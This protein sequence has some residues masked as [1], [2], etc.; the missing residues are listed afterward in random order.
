[1]DDPPAPHSRSAE[2]PGGRS[3]EL[4]FVVP[5]CN[6]AGN[7][8]PLHREITAV[9]A[10]LGPPFELIL[11]DDGS[12]DGT[13]REI[14]A[15]AASDPRL[16]CV[17]FSRNRGKSEAYAAGFSAAS[18]ERVVTLDADGQDDP[19]E[20][21]RLLAALEEG[22]D[23]VVGWKQGRFGNEPVKTVPSRFYNAL[24]GFCFGLRL[25]DSNCGFRAMRAAVAKSLRLYGDQYRFLPEI[26]HLA[27]FAVTEVPVTHRPRTRG[28]SKYGPRRFWTGLLDLLAVRFVTAYLHKPLHFFGT[29][30]LAPVFLGAVLE[31]YVLG[32][33]V[34][35]GSP[36]RHHV[37]A[38]V[39]G[40]LFLLLGVQLLTI[41]LIG[42]MLRALV[43]GTEGS[44]EHADR[45]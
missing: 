9:A 21:P 39:I 14:E 32:Q 40:V 37:A 13:A 45:A 17:R 7:V 38:L 5:A 31:L 26:A 16:V 43:P 15:L 33:K 3:P 22:Y 35:L 8:T 6:E 2:R 20:I 10:E 11:V 23:L 29:L 41:G 34:I 24:K 25:H 12:T 27:G 18:G 1:M 28:Q 36:F 44:R 19:A 4:S 30:A 42:E